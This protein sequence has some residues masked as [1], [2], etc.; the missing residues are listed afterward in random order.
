MSWWVYSVGT[1]AV[2]M[3]PRLAS[4][5]GPRGVRIGSVSRRVELSRRAASACTQ[6]ANESW[7][8]TRNS[9]AGKPR[10]WPPTCAAT[11]AALTP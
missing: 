5:T 6:T 2:S 1:V 9:V 7:L 4:G 10:T 3:R 8:G 11:V